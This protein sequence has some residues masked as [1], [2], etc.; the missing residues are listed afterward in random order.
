MLEDDSV[1]AWRDLYALDQRSE[2][3]SRECLQPMNHFLGR[4]HGVLVVDHYL[5]MSF[6]EVGP[7]SQPILA[8]ML[9]DKTQAYFFAKIE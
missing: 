1:S 6:P 3:R 9:G 8:Q 5:A 4:R 7:G 2:M